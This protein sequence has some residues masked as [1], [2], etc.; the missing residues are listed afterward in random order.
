MVSRRHPEKSWKWIKKKYFQR[1]GHR[2]WVF[3]GTDP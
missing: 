3:T 1:E 2:D